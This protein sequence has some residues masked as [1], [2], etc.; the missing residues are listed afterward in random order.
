LNLRETDQKEGDKK[1]K[2]QFERNLNEV[3]GD[4]VVRHLKELKKTKQSK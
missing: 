3:G 2:K 4:G 1:K